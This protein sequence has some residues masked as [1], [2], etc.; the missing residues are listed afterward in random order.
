MCDIFDRYI[1]DKVINHATVYNDEKTM[2]SLKGLMHL[3]D[4]LLKEKKKTRI[5]FCESECEDM[6]SCVW[7]NG[8]IWW[9]TSVEWEKANCRQSSSEVGQ[10]C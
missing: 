4:I 7:M 1:V 8:F 5:F 10:L 9:I 6:D 2:S 3:I